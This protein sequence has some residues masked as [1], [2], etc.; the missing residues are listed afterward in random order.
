MLFLAVS[1]LTRIQFNMKKVF[2]AILTLSLTSAVLTSSKEVEKQATDDVETT[3][4]A[5]EKTCDD[6]KAAGEDAMD[7]AKEMGDEMKESGEKAMDSI[8]AAGEGAMDKAKEMGTDAM[9][10]VKEMGNDAMDKTKETVSYT[11]LTLPTI[12]RV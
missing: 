9:D 11:H 8:K 7:K 5:L 2:I 3:E 10:K 4:N 6:I 12:L 1:I